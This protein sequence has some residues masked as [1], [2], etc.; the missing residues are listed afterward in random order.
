[1]ATYTREEGYPKKNITRESTEIIDQYYTVA[2][3]AVPF[4]DI[5]QFVI[6]SYCPYDY[7]LRLDRIAI[8]RDTCGKIHRVTLT[9]NY[10]VTNGGSGSTDI[11]I[12]DDDGSDISDS[13][14]S[15]ELECTMLEKD[16]RSHENYTLAWNYFLMSKTASTTIPTSEQWL[17]AREWDTSWSKDA[18]NYKE[19]GDAP[20]G[21]VV[22][23]K[24]TKPGVESYLIPSAQVIETKY[25]TK[26]SKLSQCGLNMG[27]LKAPRQTFGIVNND[28]NWRIVSVT[29]QS[30][31]QR[32]MMRR[33][34]QFANG[35]NVLGDPIGWDPE[36]SNYIGG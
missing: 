9:Y 15:Y 36:L 5:S 11:N 31:G 30:S 13:K 24:P 7:N 10:G 2:T 18:G 35:Y 32:I 14:A 8:D 25:F 16:I 19:K 27:K 20:E 21:W 29:V 1:M 4:P 33:T 17:A 12:N 6:G 22:R 23:Y 3:E 34:Y 28:Y 26:L